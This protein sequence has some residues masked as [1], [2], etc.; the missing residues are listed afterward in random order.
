MLSLFHLCMATIGNCIIDDM[1][2]DR[3]DALLEILPSRFNSDL[4]FVM[5]L[6]K[7]QRIHEKKYGRK[8]GLGEVR[9]KVVFMCSEKCELNSTQKENKSTSLNAN[10][11]M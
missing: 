4:V 6:L 7:A 9:Y 10:E 5:M 8:I 2:N 1:E 11:L 3:L